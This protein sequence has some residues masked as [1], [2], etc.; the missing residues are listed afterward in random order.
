MADAACQLAIVYADL[1]AHRLS[2]TNLAEC[3]S[4]GEHCPGPGRAGNPTARPAGQASRR[5]ALALD[6]LASDE[7]IDW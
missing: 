5:Y 4:A 6:G 3:A 2:A 7:S 1:A